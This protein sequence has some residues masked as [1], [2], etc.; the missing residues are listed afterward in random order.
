VWP[1][2]WRRKEGGLREITPE[3]KQKGGEIEQEEEGWEIHNNPPHSSL[4]SNPLQ[5]SSAALLLV[6]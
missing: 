1:H 6:K 4:L 5:T 3:K 2:T